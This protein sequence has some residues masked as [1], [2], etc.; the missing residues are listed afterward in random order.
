MYLLQIL[1][2]ML[3]ETTIYLREF[4]SNYKNYTGNY[5]NYTGS[6][7]NSIGSCGNSTGSCGNFV[8]S[9]RNSRGSY[10]IFKEPARCGTYIEP[11]R[12]ENS[13]ISY[14]KLIIQ[15]YLQPPTLEKDIHY[16]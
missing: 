8:C 5:G 7:R 1:N 16:E 14:R 11:S 12:Y 4:C 15:I 9:C 2:H 6:C 10:I 13:Y 3:E